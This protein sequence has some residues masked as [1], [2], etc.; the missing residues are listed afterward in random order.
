MSLLS[1]VVLMLLL[2]LP[3]NCWSI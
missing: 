2:R 1:P 3:K